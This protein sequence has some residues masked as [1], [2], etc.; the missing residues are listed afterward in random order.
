MKLCSSSVEVRALGTEILDG[1]L[2]NSFGIGGVSWKANPSL[3]FGCIA[4]DRLGDIC[5]AFGTRNRAYMCL[6]TL[7]PLEY[8]LLAY[9]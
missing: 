3:K 1:S 5:I 8:E 9:S 2:R 7:H 6:Q 4:L